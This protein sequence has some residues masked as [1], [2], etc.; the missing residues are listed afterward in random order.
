MTPARRLAGVSPRPTVA[1]PPLG[2]ALRSSLVRR[3]AAIIAAG[4]ALHALLHLARLASLSEAIAGD[5]LDFLSHGTL[6]AIL[7]G[8]ALE[9]FALGALLVAGLVAGAWLGERR[10]ERGRPSR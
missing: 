10:R 9:P 3:L 8:A 6:V 5:R 1:P 2:R 4:S 7:G